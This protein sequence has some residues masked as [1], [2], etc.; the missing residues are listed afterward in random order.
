[1]NFKNKKENFKK[2]YK[3]NLKEEL[4][5]FAVVSISYIILLLLVGL[6]GSLFIMVMPTVLYIYAILNILLD[7]R[8]TKNDK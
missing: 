2:I 7:L 8:N 5:L 4:G 6:D 3:S 1:M